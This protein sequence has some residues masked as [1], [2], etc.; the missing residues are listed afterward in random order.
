MKRLATLGLTLFTGLLFAA[1]CG[2]GSSAPKTA[3]LR[4]VNGIGG[5]VP[6]F[7]VLVGGATTVTNLGFNTSTAYITEASG[8]Q[9]IEFRNTGTTTDL[10]NTTANLTGGSS[11]T[12][13]SMG[14]ANQPSGV[15]FTDQTTAA[16]SGNIN[17]RIINAS[18]YVN[19][20]D[21]FFIPSTSTGNCYD[22][23]YLNSVAADISGLG[24][25]SASAYKNFAA[26]SYGLCVMP[27]GTK[28][29][30]LATGTTAYASGAVQTIVIEDNGG[31]V[32]VPQTLVD[33]S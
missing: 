13:I 30:F 31:I 14:I 12:F 21:I 1:G 26:G 9:Q 11:Y 2:G 20:I 18:A 6:G 16:T 15:L 28:T 10:I 29:A 25:G 24:F 17:L 3:Q 5:G 32:L 19:S 23:T 22:A 4:F 27:H 7:D 33:A 8:S